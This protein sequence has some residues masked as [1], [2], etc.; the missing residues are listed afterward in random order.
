MQ[1][2]MERVAL[3]SGDFVR[4]GGMD[5]PNF[6]VA[7]H[8]AQCGVSVQLV[9]FRIAPELSSDP[10]VHWHRVQKPLQSYSIGLP[11][12]LSLIHI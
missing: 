8:L 4:T 3:I 10:N 12:L 6:A 7:Q 2:V 9:A 11:L 5:M 1:L